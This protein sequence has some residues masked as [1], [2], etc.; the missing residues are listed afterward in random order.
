M[1]ELERTDLAS[2]NY[3]RYTQNMSL[4]FEKALAQLNPAQQKAVGTVEGP[5][6]ILAG[7]GTGKTQVLTLR[8][9][10]IV[11]QTDTPPQA[12]LAL[13]FTEAA[14]QNMRKRLVHF[15]G[16]DAY[17]VRIETF[18]AFC[19]DVIRSSPEHFPLRWN[20]QPLSDIERFQFL[21]YLLDTLPL[22]TLRT[23]NSAYHYLTALLKAISDLKR[24][25]VTE[26]QYQELVS[27]EAE[28]LASETEELKKT[29]RTQRQKALAQM[30]EL[31]TVYGAYQKLLYQ[32]RRYDYDDMLQLVTE[33]FQ[34]Q[35]E[36]LASYQERFLYFLVDEYQDTNTAQNTVVDLLASFWGEDAN[37]CVV[38]DPHQ[39]IYRF[40]GASFENTLGFLKRYPSAEIVF[41]REG[42][43]SPQPLYDAAA[44][45]IANNTPLSAVNQVSSTVR[46]EELNRVLA[47]PLHSRVPD[48]P[49]PIRVE[50]FHSD[51]QELQFVVEEIARLHKEGVP[52][53]EIAV[54]YRNNSDSEE[55]R[56]LLL[57]RHI[58]VCIQAAQDALAEPFTEQLL[59]F[60]A[61][62]LGL[63]AG[64]DLTTQSSVLLGPWWQLDRLILFKLMRAAG[65]TKMSLFERVDSGYPELSKLRET[66]EIL[67]IELELVRD[68]FQR[69]SRWSE[70][71]QITPLP[72]WISSVLTEAGVLNWVTQ[73]PERLFLLEQVSALLNMAQQVGQSKVGAAAAFLAAVQTMKEHH[74]ALPLQGVETH[75]GVTLSTVHKAKGR[76]WSFVFVMKCI[77]G[78]WGNTRA[79][80][81][82]PLPRGVLQ[83]ERS[84][85]EDQLEDDRRLFYVAM[86]RAKARVIITAAEQV[87]VGQTVREVL[88]SQL[89]AEIPIALVSTTAPEIS[90]QQQLD[91]LLTTLQP[92]SQLPWT[93]KEQT[94]LKELVQDL[95]LSVSALNLYLRSPEDFFYQVILKVP[96]PPQPQL[97]FGT[98]V[99]ATL[100]MIYRSWKE[101]HSLPT[102]GDVLQ[103]FE[104]VL[105]QGQFSSEEFQR[106]L[107]HGREVIL[108]YLR[109]RPITTS[110]PLFV[111]KFFGY[112]TDTTMLGDI[113]LTGRIDRVD[114]KDQATKTAQLIDY[115]TGRS[116]TI[117]EIDGKV[118]TA[119]YSE[120]EL[121]LPEPLRGP[122]KRQLL[123]YKLLLQLDHSFTAQVQSG[124]FEYV[125]PVDGKYLTRELALLDE[126]VKLLKILIQEVM[127]EIRELKFLTSMT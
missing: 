54:L 89:I 46:I 42:Y 60:F 114:W 11:Q 115:K 68:V 96:Q 84:P 70:E 100:E 14:A 121:S 66:K 125:E 25:G 105:E 103:R 113:R 57:K 6:M 72:T 63:R 127:A 56:E 118:G 21:E 32:K 94:W 91:F 76:E 37:L 49:Q 120:R 99:H 7:P 3:P 102:E 61:T 80:R 43:R 59:T 71:E 83:F 73:Q 53:S 20:S 15:L 67:P 41:L 34:T 31:G 101:T 5:L 13:T 4:S 126:D 33:A 17:K 98:A 65:K 116:K 50:K 77:D 51:R 18:H 62:T 55:L 38:G 26:L 1:V 78:K 40:Q 44:A 82:L 119:E 22:D 117:N 97:A 109:T 58:P 87:M 95:P 93:E 52:T 48:Q 92:A 12:I 123:F 104:T 29:E 8:I 36:L 2:P 47:T 9:A 88:P 19:D 90:D 108:A 28:L 107:M 106:R 45:V 122:Y 85:K 10:Q 64:Q 35:P 69:M 39:S 79:S 24:E 23:V 124:V 81:S 86:T 111:E 16:T 110:Q 74:L 75:Q 30:Q 27:E 112:G